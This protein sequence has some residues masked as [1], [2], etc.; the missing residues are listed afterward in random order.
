MY[1]FPGLFLASLEYTTDLHLVQY[2]IGDVPCVN[3]EQTKNLL[4]KIVTRNSK[5]DFHEK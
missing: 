3:A 5:N 4:K 2:C 1:C